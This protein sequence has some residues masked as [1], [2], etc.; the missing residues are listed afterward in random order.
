MMV[1]Y[2]QK[3]EKMKYGEECAHRFNENCFEAI[4][5][6]KAKI[7]DVLSRTDP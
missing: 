1:A 6:L 4:T 3:L 5:S 2:L 7:K